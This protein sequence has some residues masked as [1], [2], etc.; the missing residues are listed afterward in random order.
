M[1]GH[2]RPDCQADELKIVN[3]DLDVEAL[4]ERRTQDLQLWA[5]QDRGDVAAVVHFWAHRRKLIYEDVV[6]ETMLTSLALE[7]LDVVELDWPG[8]FAAGRKMAV[9]GIDQTPGN[10]QGQIDTFKLSLRAPAGADICETVSQE[11]PDTSCGDSCTVQC[12]LPAQLFCTGTCDGQCVS[13]CTAS[14]QGDCDGETDCGH[15]ESEPPPE[16]PGCGWCVISDQETDCGQ[17]ETQ[18]QNCIVSATIGIVGCPTN[19]EQ[20]CATCCRTYSCQTCCRV[21][22]ASEGECA[23]TVQQQEC[24]SSCVG[25][26]I[27]YCLYLVQPGC[28]SSC[29]ATCTTNRQIIEDYPCGSCQ[30]DSCTQSCTTWNQCPGEV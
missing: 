23:T 17:W 14:K 10:A 15:T 25:G 20:G 11:P 24:G 27:T 7:R 21:S 13:Q 28:S 29:T 1:V 9:L 8:Q 12:Q 3:R 19:T 6:L 18:C 2:Y 16:I 26:A 5:Y 30:I 4:Y 22:P